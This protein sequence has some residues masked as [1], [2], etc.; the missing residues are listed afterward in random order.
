MLEAL[1]SP[2]TVPMKRFEPVEGMCV[3]KGGYSAKD[4]AS[5]ALIEKEVSGIIYVCKNFG[6]DTVTLKGVV[7]GL[8]PMQRHALY[9]WSVV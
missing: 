9:I 8:N 3:L 5:G 6:K 7:R 1:T 2:R 4:R